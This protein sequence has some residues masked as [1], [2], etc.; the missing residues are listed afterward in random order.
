MLHT[1]SHRSNVSQRT[2]T[3]ALA[4][5]DGEPL[6]LHR[7]P[8]ACCAVVA[9]GVGVAWAWWAHALPGCYPRPAAAAV[10]TGAH[11]R[12]A[13]VHAG[14]QVG[15]ARGG[16]ASRSGQRVPASPPSLCQSAP[17]LQTAGIFGNLA[18]I[19]APTLLWVHPPCAQDASCPSLSRLYGVDLS[20]TRYLGPPL[21]PRHHLHTYPELRFEEYNT[22]AYLQQQLADMG[23]GFRAPYA[24]TGIAAVIGKEEREEEAG[25]GGGGRGG[26][27]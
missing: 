7:R 11:T 27:R 13:A 12:H 15:G 16:G 4:S 5:T 10:A 20:P 1:D 23:I 3:A 17:A 14:M 21:P 9:C 26:G 19:H 6:L 2:A 8:V 18:P 22:S 24:G 25:E